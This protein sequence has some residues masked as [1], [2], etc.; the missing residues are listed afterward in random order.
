MVHH[1]EIKRRMGEADIDSLARLVEVASLAD[2]HRALGEHKW[3]D[4]VQGGR[5]GFAGFIAREPAHQRV[6]GY[7]QIS[8]GQS[9]SWAV[10][11]VLH[12][13]WRTPDN[14]LRRDLVRAALDEIGLQGGGHV[15]L[16]VPMPSTVDDSVAESV[17]LRRGRDI[18]QM[19]RPLPMEGLHAGIATRAFRPGRDEER[20]LAV[21]NRAFRLHPEQGVWTLETI[22]DRELQDWFDPDG[23]LLHEVGDEL[24]GFCWTKVHDEEQLGEIYVIAVNPDYQGRG[25]GREL[26]LAGLDYLATREVP[27]AMLY[28]DRD[29]VPARS[30]YKEIGFS[31]DHLDRA[32]TGDIAAAGGP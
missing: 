22:A 6:I 21:N 28:V 11:Y 12:P 8:R 13:N 2:G 4:L 14:G 23:F 29:N 32:Y 25:L 27:T 16:W 20:W 15:H 1:L 26:L 7:A 18:H 24:A 10:E 30:L 3:L 17:G 5:E 19:R 9:Q 31:D